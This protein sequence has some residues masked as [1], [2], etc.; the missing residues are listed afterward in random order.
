VVV[1]LGRR[2]GRVLSCLIVT[3][4]VLAGLG[5]TASA[6]R[7]PGPPTGLQASPLSISEMKISWNPVAGSEGYQISRATTSGG[8]YEP[9]IKVNATATSY[10]DRNLSPGT[11][12]YYVV[13][14]RYR[15]RYSG[16][17]VEVS[18]STPEPVGAPDNFTATSTGSTMELS[19]DPVS[20]VERYEVMRVLS[21]DTE[22][23]LGTTTG[24]RFSDAGVV[25][26]HWYWYKVRS[27]RGLAIADSVT[28]YVAAGQ[29]TTTALSVSPIPNEEGQRVVLSAQVRLPGQE[30]LIYEGYVEFFMDGASVGRISIDYYDHDAMFQVN[31]LSVG[32]HVFHAQYR[33]GNWES[34]GASASSTVEQ[35]TVPSYGGVSFGV[36][37]VHDFGV[38][39]IPTGVAI[40]D[41]TGDGRNDVLMTTQYHS[42][43]ENTDFKLA[44]FA[45]RSDRTLAAPVVLSSHASTFQASMRIATGD[46]DADGD[47]DVA[48]AGNSGVDVYRQASGALSQPTLLTNPEPT[49]DLVSADLNDDGRSDLV[50]S[51]ATP[52][53]LAYLGQP[54]GFAA[55][56]VVSST[57]GGWVDAADLNS[58]GRTDIVS[59]DT[60][61]V[62]VHAQTSVG[63]FVEETRIADVPDM[64]AI[65][66]GDITG[67]GRADI[68][69]TKSSNSPYAGVFVY[70]QTST[71]SI[72]EPVLYGLYDSPEPVVLADVDRDGRRDLVTAHGGWNY[73]SVLLQ[74]P[75]GLLGRSQM[76]RIPNITSH[77]DN[78]GLAVGDITGDGKP[79]LAIADYLRGL[80]IVPQL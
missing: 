70:P 9:V 1:R 25:S 7:P 67:D 80:V 31:G 41:V 73:S 27:V 68:A 45:Q 49:G 13:S 28:L 62:V 56:V 74:R 46:F 50:V 44:V 17:S 19:W 32:R 43:S 35:T 34:T 24:T 26:G 61:D 10:V 79:D 57:T 4:V 39:S 2:V 40:A 55:P 59:S 58:D 8:P 37:Q 64:R 22:V 15:F 72:G 69:T 48:V 33:G 16:H 20:D 6:A 54:A 42:G 78:R 60:H 36:S 52:R 23:P 14:T 75:D 47:T 65:A 30:H 51:D 63:S 53:T 11:T 12:Y 77:Y 29:P 5:T 3:I 71:G 18:A 76:V 66:V 38:E 21:D